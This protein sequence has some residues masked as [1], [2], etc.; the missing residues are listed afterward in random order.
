MIARVSHMLGLLVSKSLEAKGAKMAKGR[1]LALT[2]LQKPVN[3][4]VDTISKHS[5]LQIK[6]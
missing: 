5:V 3:L 2:T 4:C 6:A 1:E